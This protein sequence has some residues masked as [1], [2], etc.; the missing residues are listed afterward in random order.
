MFVLESEIF[1]LIDTV[2]C[3]AVTVCKIC[4]STCSHTIIIFMENFICNKK[5]HFHKHLGY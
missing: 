2:A 3:H 5:R 4:K 1:M